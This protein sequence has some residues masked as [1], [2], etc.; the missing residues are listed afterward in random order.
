M[1]KFSDYLIYRNTKR[2]N[3]KTIKV[4]GENNQFLIEIL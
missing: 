4:N 1:N 2:V 3:I